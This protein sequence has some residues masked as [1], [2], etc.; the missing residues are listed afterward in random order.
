MVVM[1]VGHVIMKGNAQEWTFTSASYTRHVKSR[2]R[3][4]R[5]NQLTGAFGADVYINVPIGTIAKNED[6]EVIGEI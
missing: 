3:K 2:R 1:V 5:Q 4:W 6:G